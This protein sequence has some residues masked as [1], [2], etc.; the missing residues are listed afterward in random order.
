[1]SK[2]VVVAR[3]LRKSYGSISALGGIDLD[4][5][6]GRIVGLIGRN[7][8]GKTTALKAILGLTAYEGRLEVLGLDPFR[9]RRELMQQV[10]FIA[11]VAVLPHYMTVEQVLEFVA[12]SHPRFD[13]EKARAI[14]ATSEVRPGARVKTL[15]KGMVTQLHLSLVLAI[16]ARLLVLDEPTLGL[17]IVFRNQFYGTLLA[18]YFE[19]SKTI[20]VTTHQVEE[21]EHILTD[22]IFID[23][24]EVLLAHTMD[25][26]GERYREVLVAPDRLA[27][28]RGFHPIAERESL[29]QN[30]LLFEDKLEDD[31]RALGE[32]RA[33]R[34]AD[35]FIAKLQEARRENLRHSA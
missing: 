23:K 17:D 3:G 7:G 10:S 27:D 35:L 21:L 30:V 8:A 25:V 16:D 15:S 18:E 13:M 9:R 19:Q 31:L 6:P 32:C 33:P 11:D 20:L 5:A 26:L 4:I 14:L 22:V 2:P 24:G 12:A 28:A 29:G 1:M 34:V